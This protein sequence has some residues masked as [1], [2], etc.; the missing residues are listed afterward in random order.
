M[1]NK[2]KRN[3][4][5]TEL[6]K[7]FGNEIAKDIEESIYKFSQNYA[8]DNGTPFLLENIYCLGTIF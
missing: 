2:E 7:K 3:T 6:N 4:I 8:D 1:I 5:F